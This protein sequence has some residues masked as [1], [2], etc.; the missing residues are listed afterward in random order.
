MPDQPIRNPSADVISQW[1]EF[2]EHVTNWIKS[3]R[4]RK[5][6]NRFGSISEAIRG[7]ESVWGGCGVYTTSE[8]LFIAGNLPS[9]DTHL[10]IRHTHILTPI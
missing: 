1:P 2:V 6:T 3:R 8:I 10:S 5:M 9:I 4:E 7:D